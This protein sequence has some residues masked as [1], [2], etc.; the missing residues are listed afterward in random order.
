MSEHEKYEKA[1]VEAGFEP[2]QIISEHWGIYALKDGS[3][4]KLRPNII[5]IARETDAYGNM[6]FNVNANVT[7]GIISPKNMRGPPL[8]RPP[9][10]Q[11]I[12]SAIIDD[13]VG[14]LVVEEE[15]STYR[16]Q[17]GTILSIKLIPIQISR[18]SIHDPNGEPMY[19]INHQLL[20]KA[21]VPEELRKKGIRVQQSITG[22][23][24]TFIT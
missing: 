20:V 5:K 15:W 21:S 22:R 6:A 19:N 11:E 13:D 10:P 3:Y 4:L 24:P 14:F 16:L 8:T 2:F 12:A 17:D 7:I 23:N 18:T 9:T 1:L